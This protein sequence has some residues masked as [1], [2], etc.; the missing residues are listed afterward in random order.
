MT[1]D[2]VYLKP[3]VVIEPLVNR[4]YAWSHLIS[5]ATAAMNIIGR[6]LKIMDSYIQDP[7]IHAEVVK[8][9][10][11]RGGPFMDLNGEKLEEVKQLRALTLSNQQ[12]MIELAD[13]IK[14]LDRMLQTNAK[15]YSLDSLYG[16]VPASL[17]GYVE[18]VY[19]LNGHPSYRFFESLLYNSKY[20]NASTQSIALWITNNDERPFCLSTPRVDDESI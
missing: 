16:K 12:D 4:W 1:A 19:D 5:P 17:A 20:Y 13:S 7:Q 10:L 8:N 14:A 9:P 11:M 3:N 18:L 15:G 6:H 2:T